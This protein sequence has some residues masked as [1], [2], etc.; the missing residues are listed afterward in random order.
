MEETIKLTNNIV[1]VG[2]QRSG[3]T[4]L[5]KLI[6][7]NL[8]LAAAFESYFIPI[9][10][11]YRYLWGD[12]TKLKNRKNMLDAIFLYLESR[13]SA[14]DELTQKTKE[15]HTLLACK[16]HAREIASES[17]SYKELVLNLFKYYSIQKGNL[18][19]VEKTAYHDWPPLPTLGGFFENALFVHLVRDPLDTYSSWK[20]T[21]F[22]PKYAG[23]A[24]YIW[25]KINQ[26]CHDWGKENPSRYILIKYEE[27]VLKPDEQI[28]HIKKRLDLKYTPPQKENANQESLFES[29]S[30][31][32]WFKNINS[33]IN[34]KNKNTKKNI[35]RMEAAIIKKVTQKVAQ[36]YNYKFNNS[37]EG[38]LSIRVTALIQKIMEVFTLNTIK[39][40]IE[41]HFPLLIRLAQVT[42]TEK[43]L[44]KLIT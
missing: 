35:S 8:N 6:S 43:L 31:K 33:D 41:K 16:A 2:T 4:L 7:E 42:K 3:T 29:I 17:K 20:E 37:S 26:S 9:F 15:N 28:E 24:A 12:L 39:R 27:L 5:Q 40:Q 34:V 30:D 13:Y 11:K 32:S 18:G 19:F 38:R 22:S 23:A 14:A 36:K 21:W 1:I 44:L 25:K 10:E